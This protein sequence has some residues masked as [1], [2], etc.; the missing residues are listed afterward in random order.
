M[1]LAQAQA[2]LRRAPSNVD[3]LRLAAAAHRRLGDGS[4]AERAELAAIHH[5]E[6]NPMLRAAARLLDEGNPGEASRLAAERLRLAPDDLAALTMSAEA[7]LA[8][9]LPHKAEPLL[10]RVLERA[11]SFVPAAM[12]QINVLLMQDRLREA[13]SLVEGVIARRPGDKAALRLS[14]RIRADSGDHKAAAAVYERLLEQDEQAI[15]IWIGY[16]DSLRFL[17]RADESR[18]AYL[19]ALEIDPGCGLAWWSLVNLDPGAVADKQIEAMQAALDERAGQPEHSGNLHFALGAVHEARSRYAEAFHHVQ[20]GNALRLTAQPYDP[21]EVTRKVDRYVR[22]LSQAAFPARAAAPAGR[23]VPVFIVGMPRSG[24][25]LVERILGRHTQVEAAGELPIIPHIVESIALEDAQAPVEERILALSEGR[26]QQ[27]ADRY[28]AR[29]AERRSTDRPWFVD[30][31][32]MNWRHLPMILQIL[33]HARIIDVRRSPLDC[34]WSNYKLLFA[35]G[36]PAASELAHLGRFYVDYVRL[37]AHLERTAPGALLRVHYE[38]LIDDLEGQTRRMLAYLDLPYE[39]ACLDFHLATTPVATA[40][41]EQVRRPL[42]R[43]GIGVSKPFEPWLGPLK[44][45]LGPVL[46]LYPD[47]PSAWK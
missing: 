25:T 46:D 36:H 7:A 40:S 4:L 11:P 47:V 30:K 17:G 9:Q 5:S 44:K 14:A 32:H 6:S 1:A 38:E 24:S 41:S 18:K 45:A 16:G 21:D 35:R 43:D 42:N 37:V 13:L 23:P 33:P 34:C 3:A 15:E 22:L 39:P 8:L 28:L 31:L 20:Q 10:L 2:I 19:R 26:R 12:L 29:A 27:L